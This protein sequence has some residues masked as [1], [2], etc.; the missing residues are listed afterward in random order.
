M[1]NDDIKGFLQPKDQISDLASELAFEM[2]HPNTPQ[3]GVYQIFGRSIN[4]EK[5]TPLNGYI[6][7]VCSRGGYSLPTMSRGIFGEIRATPDFQIYLSVENRKPSKLFDCIREST[8]GKRT[9]FKICDVITKRE[10]GAIEIVKDDDNPK[11]YLLGFSFEEEFSI[12]LTKKI[13]DKVTPSLL[14]RFRNI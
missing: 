1:D 4:Q 2:A 7:I 14:N 9:I 12:Y 10:V 11:V 6:I 13:H 3:S 8:G 5:P